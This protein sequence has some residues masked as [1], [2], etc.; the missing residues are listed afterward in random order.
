MCSVDARTDGRRT[1]HSHKEI[2]NL[3]I[4]GGKVINPTNEFELMTII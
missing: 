4:N 2:R 3:L 1:V